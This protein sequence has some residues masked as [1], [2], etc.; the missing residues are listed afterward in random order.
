MA[1]EVIAKEKGSEANTGKTPKIN[2]PCNKNH[3]KG[4]VSY[5]TSAENPGRGKT[6]KKHERM[7]CNWY[8]QKGTY[9][10]SSNKGELKCCNT[11]L[12]LVSQMNC[13]REKSTLAQY[14][15][16]KDAHWKKTKE[17]LHNLQNDGD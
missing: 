3:T 4:S 12:T 15:D 8:R 16:V 2:V 6:V 5:G 17:L 10:C 14:T 13:G 7:Q 1:G 9:F 11:K